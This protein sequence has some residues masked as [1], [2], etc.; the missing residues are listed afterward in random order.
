M[1]K[2]IYGVGASFGAILQYAFVVAHP[3]KMLQHPMDMVGQNVAMLL[4]AYCIWQFVHNG[5]AVNRLRAKRRE[6]NGR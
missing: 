4:T 3:G 2:I 1:W 6:R 5:Q